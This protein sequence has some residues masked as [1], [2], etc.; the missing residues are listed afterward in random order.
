[1]LV[2]ILT[3]EKSV[4]EGEAEGITLPG[5]LGL[6][7][8]LNNHA[9]ILT[10]LK[11]GIFKIKAADSSQSFFIGGG[12]VEFSNN[13][14]VVLA[15]SFEKPEEIDINRALQAVK[16]AKKRLKDRKDVDVQRAEMALLR[17]LARQKVY[18]VSK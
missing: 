6:M 2:S 5:E 4:F 16:R 10:S 3:P 8:I 13:K 18:S 17:G 15:D 14:A 11:P 1:M 7:G 9:P 12:F